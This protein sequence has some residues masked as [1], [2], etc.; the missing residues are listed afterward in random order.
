VKPLLGLLML[1]EDGKGGCVLEWLRSARK[2]DPR[3]R[4]SASDATSWGGG[5]RMLLGEMSLGLQLD[6]ESWPS[7]SMSTSFDSGTLPGASLF[8]AIER[9]SKDSLSGGGS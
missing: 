5:F 4:R 3:W 2:G 1:D 7:S 9:C 8:S 6:S